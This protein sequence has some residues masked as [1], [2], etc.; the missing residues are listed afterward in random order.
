MTGR[1]RSWV[2]HD[3][4]PRKILN[5]S[6]ALHTDTDQKKSRNHVI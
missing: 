6:F 2:S 4:T 1:Y 5:D 3:A